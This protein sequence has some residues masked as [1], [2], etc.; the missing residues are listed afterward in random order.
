MDRVQRRE[1]VS[2]ECGYWSQWSVS[3]KI[4]TISENNVEWTSTQCM[5]LIRQTVTI[6][7]CSK[8]SSCRKI[9]NRKSAMNLLIV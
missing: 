1:K 3:C 2:M 9:E 4:V 8:K 5:Q 6:L 7:T